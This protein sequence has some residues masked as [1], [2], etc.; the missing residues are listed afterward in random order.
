MRYTSLVAA[1][2]STLTMLAAAPS[3]AAD[4]KITV[5][6]VASA[7]GQVLVALYNSAE[8]YQKKA[9]RVAGAPA[10]AGAITI[11]IKD[12]PPGD[13][14]YSLFHDANGN[15]KLDSNVIGIPTEDYAFSNNAMGKFGPP[16]YEAARFTL[17]AAGATTSVNLR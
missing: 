10:V 4:L 14:A 17:P 9:F 5:T 11:E 2:L 8:T 3:Q 1:A 6:G 15:G 7:D 16:A 13:Y 12:V